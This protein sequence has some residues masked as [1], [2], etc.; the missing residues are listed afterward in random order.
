MA[1]HKSAKKRIKTSEKRRLY[2]RSIKSRVKTYTRYFRE[3]IAE[4]LED[5]AHIADHRDKNYVKLQKISSEFHRAVSKGV[6]PKNTAGR[7]IGRL[8]LLFNKTFANWFLLFF[9]RDP[10]ESFSVSLERE[11]LSGFVFLG[12][13]WNILLLLK[14]F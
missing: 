11:F 7:K 2:N 12:S 9:H 13:L 10:I 6:I 3:G 4:A 1:H 5:V 8:T 14:I